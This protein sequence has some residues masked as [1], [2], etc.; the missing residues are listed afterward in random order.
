MLNHGI[1]SARDLICST[2]FSFSF[3]I[4]SM[5]LKYP[6][7]SIKRLDRQEEKKMSAE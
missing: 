2:I 6:I 3:V 5:A 7:E 4:R 1:Y